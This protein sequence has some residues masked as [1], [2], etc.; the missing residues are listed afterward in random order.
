MRIGENQMAR[1]PQLFG[2]SND[3]MKNRVSRTVFS[4]T[5]SQAACLESVFA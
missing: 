3:E 1:C 2:G 4:P 5:K